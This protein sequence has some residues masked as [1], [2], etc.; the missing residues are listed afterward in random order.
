MNRW[1]PVLILMSCGEAEPEPAEPAATPR[2]AVGV[3]V[4]TFTLGELGEVE[5]WYPAADSE[6]EAASY[7]V[8]GLIFDVDTLALRDATPATGAWPLVVFSHGLG[9]FRGQS[10]FL[11]EAL[12]EAGFVVLAIDHPGTTLDDLT[13]TDL[14]RA[15]GA[16]LAGGLYRWFLTLPRRWRTLPIALVAGFIGAY[17][18]GP[19]VHAA[20]LASGLPLPEDSEP[21]LLASQFVAGF[22]GMTI[23]RMGLALAESTMRART[24]A[25]NGGQDDAS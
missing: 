12:A 14:G 6:G 5:V 7:N 24:R 2:P 3:G 9:G 22:G 17:F 19:V 18:M 15:V 16:G 20:W 21:A 4:Q 23:A 13:A 1:L 8:G 10:Y 11:T 25:A